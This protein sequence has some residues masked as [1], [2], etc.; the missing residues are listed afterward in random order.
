MMSIDIRFILLLVTWNTHSR[1][2]RCWLVLV[3]KIYMLMT[4]QSCLADFGQYEQY[5]N[6]ARGRDSVRAEML[7]IHVYS[8]VPGCA[9]THELAKFDNDGT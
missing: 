1:Y 8:L 4:C 2:S 3:V 9:H 5:K 6:R 7:G